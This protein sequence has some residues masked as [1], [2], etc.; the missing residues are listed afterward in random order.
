MRV[1]LN[2]TAGLSGGVWDVPQLLS[3]AAVRGGARL[4]LPAPGVPA[5]VPHDELAV[6]LRLRLDDTEAEEL[7]QH[8]GTEQARRHRNANRREKP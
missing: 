3:S 4:R 7:R 2:L 6:R 8:A 5:A 1:V